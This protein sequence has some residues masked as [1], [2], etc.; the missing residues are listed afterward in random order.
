M[1][2]APDFVSFF[3][4][5]QPEKLACVDL[6]SGRRWDY[7]AF[8]LAIDRAVAAI[9]VRFAM[10]PGDRLA[11]IGKNSAD[12]VILHL[13]CLR[14]GIIFVPLN[15]RC[16]A[17][18]I[19]AAVADCSPA[20]LVS[21]VEFAHLIPRQGAM[22]CLTAPDVVQAMSQAAPKR[23]Q[24]PRDGDRPAVLLYTS[25]T[26]GVPKGVTLTSGNIYFSS[27]NFC[28]LGRV[29]GDSVFLCDAPMFHVIGLVASLHAPIVRGGTMVISNGFEPGRTI[30]YM[31]DRRLGITHYFC[32]PQMAARIR[33]H[34]TFAPEKLAGLVA[35]FTGGA[36]HP[37][38]AINAWLDLGIAVADGFGM[39]ETGTLLGMPIDFG[40]IRAKAGS[41]GVAA[42]HV[43][44]RIVA[45]DGSD[46]GEGRSGELWVRGPS[47]S[48]GYWNRPKET[49]SAFAGEG[50][51]RSGD[52]AVMDADGYVTI[53]GRAKDMFIS[54][55]ENVYA[56]EVET[57]L[58]QHP[59]IAEAAVMGQADEKWGEVGHAY[60]VAR[61]GAHQ[62]ADQ[63]L[64]AFCAASL[65]RFKIPQKYRWLRELPR[66]ASG[67]VN[68]RQLP[69]DE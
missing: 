54:G 52:I 65:A 48:A 32:V 37:A 14:A 16:S 64:D 51:F 5:T 21:D 46:A 11:V 4:R 27:L 44:M 29:G 34:P 2:K 6:P 67:K 59:A 28:A 57:R 58:L 61:N 41:C 20:V 18:E 40:L 33:E 22:R 62:P 53:V 19:A 23:T 7:R 43:E 9:E 24:T 56:G 47:I 63:D 49:A 26:T 17:T 13:A 60:L 50:W 42:P 10:D 38:N 12:Y 68:K 15:W 35:L 8:D 36:P 39:T 69:K 30:G 3:A 55:G 1:N 25:G 45:A 31:A 66:T